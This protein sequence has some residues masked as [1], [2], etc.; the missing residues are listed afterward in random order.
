MPEPT[1]PSSYVSS[2]NPI[3]RQLLVELGVDFLWGESIA[4]AKGYGS[5]HTRK[6]L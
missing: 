3:Q 6:S 4:L 2:L 1:L 5:R